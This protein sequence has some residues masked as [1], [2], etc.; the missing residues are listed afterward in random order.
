MTRTRLLLLGLSYAMLSVPSVEAAS[1]SLTITSEPAGARIEVNGKYMGTTPFTWKVGNW[2]LNPRKSWITAEHLREPL[3]M[4][5][6][7]DGYVPK[8]I[9][10]TG[11]PL[12][13]TT[14]NGLNGFTY[15]VIQSNEYH[16]KLDKVG[17][18]LGGNPFNALPPTAMP[19]TTPGIEVMID[20]AMASVVTI[21]AGPA[22]GS[23][24]LVNNKGL[25]I[26][27]KHVVGSS[28]HARVLNAAGQV[29]ETD[30]IFVDPDHD[31]AAVKIDCE[32]CP[33]LT[34]AEPVS[35]VVGQEV[36]AIGSP[37][38]PGIGTFRNTVTRG[39]VSAFRGPNDAG[40]V[41]IQTDAAINPGNSGG[42][43]LNKYGFVVGVNTLKVVAE[44]YS[45]LNFA[46]SSNDVFV[47]LD[48]QFNYRA[49]RGSP[50]TEQPPTPIN[51]PAS[52]PQLTGKALTNDDIVALKNAGL[53]D[54][55]IATKIKTT[56]ANYSLNTEDLISLKRANVPDGVIQ[57]M[58]EAQAR[59]K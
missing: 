44:G 40:H 21:T 29:F 8:T 42:P 49:P 54:E 6:I 7:E 35:I 36:L 34:L 13:F 53:L 2:A 19:G 10:L 25:V 30:S 37:G 39:I 3:V 56:P 17:E 4:T 55:L 45:G 38:L 59:G 32:Q 26:T 28:G 41:Y 57:A 31:L 18:F 12:R 5:L 43:L 11:Q 46:I 27:N 23:G 15:Y 48:R 24:F 14:I 20:R 1:D 22:S 16:V 33:Y 58:I 50:P 47:M 51:P 9:Q 52:L